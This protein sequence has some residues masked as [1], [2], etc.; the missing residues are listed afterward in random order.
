MS[1]SIHHDNTDDQDAKLFKRLEE[2]LDQIELEEMV[3]GFSNE[4]LKERGFIGDNNIVIERKVFTET[5]EHEKLSFK[6]GVE[7]KRLPDQMQFTDLNINDLL[8]LRDVQ[9]D[10]LIATRESNET[11][12]FNAGT[13]VEKLID[14]DGEKYIAKVKGKVL[15]I[16]D[17]L[18]VFPSDIDCAL[19]IRVSEN[20]MMVTMDCEAGYGGGRHLTLQSVMNALDEMGVIHG[21]QKDTIQK[22]IEEAEDLMAP[23]H[24]IIVAE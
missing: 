11:I 1:D 3:K 9:A 21:I 18:Y 20:K 5:T 23:Q 4:E 2:N 6:E 24:E 16:K 13:N 12:H 22:T 14:D 8:L 7:Y 17:A 10:M 19:K 15:I